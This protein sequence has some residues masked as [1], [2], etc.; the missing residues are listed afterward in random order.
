MTLWELYLRT[1]LS[2]RVAICW[3]DTIAWH[4]IIFGVINL[5]LW[6][7]K[8]NYNGLIRSYSFNICNELRYDLLQSST[9]SNHFKDKENETPRFFSKFH[10]L[11][12]NPLLKSWCL[13]LFVYFLKWPSGGKEA[14]A[15]QFEFG[16]NYISYHDFLP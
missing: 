12:I 2:L 3:K 8:G 5:F 13:T 6:D 4:C 1:K 10:S 11:Y 16:P 14:F 15:H 9:P 7:L